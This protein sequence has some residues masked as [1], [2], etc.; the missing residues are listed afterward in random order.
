VI[1]SLWLG[2]TYYFHALPLYVGLPLAGIIVTWQS[3]LQHECVH[4]HPSSSR[5]FNSIFAGPSLWLYLPFSLYRETHLKHHAS[6]ELTSP[7]EDSESFYFTGKAWQR[8]G[9]IRRAFWTSHNTLLGRLVLGPPVV[10]FRLAAAEISLLRQ[11][12]LT[13]VPIWIVHAAVVAAILWW[14][15]V[16]CDLATWEYMLYFVYPGMSLSLLRSF[17]E[18]KPAGSQVGRSA[19]IEAGPALTLLFLS[20]NLHLLHHKSPLLP[21]YG[22]KAAY[23]KEREILL[24][25]NDNLV[26]AGYSEIARRFF[27]RPVASPKHPTVHR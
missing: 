19:I 22:M 1:Y 27:F 14:T 21:W 13:H 9:A 8:F 15:R 5:L 7:N 10:L 2:L 20:N 3:S 23:Q 18:H 25:Q 4:D 16:M 24:T 11:G 6:K 12:D 26:Y 17:A